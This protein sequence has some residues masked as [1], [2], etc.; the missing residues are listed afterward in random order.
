MSK[1]RPAPLGPIVGHAAAS[2]ALI[3]IRGSAGDEGA[4]VDGECR[5]VFNLAIA[6]YRS[7]QRVHGP[8]SYG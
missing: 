8:C 7:Y 3:W 1:P 5:R 2:S 4:D 6:A